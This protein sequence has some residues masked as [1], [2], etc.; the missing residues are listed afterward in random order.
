[1]QVAE[2]D[3]LINYELSI[4][5]LWVDF[6]GPPQLT[7]STFISMAKAICSHTF[8]ILSHFFL[9]SEFSTIY[10]FFGKP[11]SSGT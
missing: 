1:M 2:V 3:L 5:L 6:M 4:Q 7:A 9:E 10:E 11:H 8:D